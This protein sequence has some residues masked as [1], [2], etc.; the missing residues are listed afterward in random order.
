MENITKR[1]VASWKTRKVKRNAGAGVGEARWGR[2]LLRK[3]A[4]GLA[5]VVAAFQDLSAQS[6]AALT[7]R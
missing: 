1:A 3:P 4:C 7:G 6:I 2:F 5:I